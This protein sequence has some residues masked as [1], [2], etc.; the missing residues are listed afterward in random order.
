MSLHGISNMLS[1]RM[2]ERHRGT[3]PPQY[4]LAQ[5]IEV[6]AYEY[7]PDDVLPQHEAHRLNHHLPLIQFMRRLHKQICQNLHI[8]SPVPLR[9]PSN[10]EDTYALMIL[11]DY[12][13]ILLHSQTDYS[14]KL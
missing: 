14:P 12:R 9:E 8:L 13:S 2:I 7:I 3:Y 1:M 11:Y 5:S 6:E 10:D 4:R